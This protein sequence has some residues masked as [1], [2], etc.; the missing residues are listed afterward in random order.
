MNCDKILHVALNPIIVSILV[1]ASIRL[2]HFFKYLNNHTVLNKQFSAEITTSRD[3]NL[4]FLLKIVYVYYKKKVVMY[5][6]R[7]N[8]SR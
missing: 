5:I 3:A 1:S 6:S 7:K 2:A 8:Y 4:Y